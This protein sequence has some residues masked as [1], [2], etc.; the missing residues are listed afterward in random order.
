MQR[1][2]LAAARRFQRSMRARGARLVPT[3]VPL[4]HASRER[5]AIL[6]AELG[7]PFVAPKIPDMATSDCLHPTPP[8]ARQFARE[9][10][11]RLC[12]ELA[13]TPGPWGSNRSDLLSWRLLH[14]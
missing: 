13:K 5:T 4:P 3:H 1:N 11:D 9:F 14:T 7:V 12:R 2:K 6:A 10:V 8:C